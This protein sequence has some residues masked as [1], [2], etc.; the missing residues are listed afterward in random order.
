MGYTDDESMVR[1]DFFKE[2]GKWYT[3][4][5]VR[6]T[7]EWGGNSVI[8]EEFAKSLRDHFSKDVGSEKRLSEMDAIC[9]YPYH[10]NKHPIQIK[11][12]GWL[13]YKEKK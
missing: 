11:K 3:T 6:W 4:E 1:V 9:L 12:G 5:A 13:L 10:K 2:S 7:G 8:H